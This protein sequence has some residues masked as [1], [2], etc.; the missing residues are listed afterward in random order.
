MK[1]KQQNQ[2]K[3]FFELDAKNWSVKAQ[4]KK[5][6]ERSQNQQPQPPNG[7][8]SIRQLRKGENRERRVRRK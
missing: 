2:T 6:N 3:N 8:S 1:Y 4:F 5:Q 7:E